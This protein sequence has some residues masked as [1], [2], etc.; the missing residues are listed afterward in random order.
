MMTTVVRAKEH[1]VTVTGTS[2]ECTCGNTCHSVKA[3]GAAEWALDHMD[4]VKRKA[5]ED[6]TQRFFDYTDREDA[7]LKP[8]RDAIQKADPLFS[9]TI[10]TG[11]G[12]MATTVTIES[13][14]EYGLVTDLDGPWMFCL[15][16][17]EEGSYTGEGELITREW[18]ATTPLAEVGRLVAETT[19][20]Y[21]AKKGR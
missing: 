16:K 3:T 9:E 6:R 17:N 19:M 5:D 13:R 12:C 14:N 1:K 8:L 2:A 18:P 10:H 21:L 7:R 20:A 11:G 15:Y 4:P